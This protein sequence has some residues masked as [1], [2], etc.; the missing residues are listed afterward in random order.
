MVPGTAVANLS[1][2]TEHQ[3][4]GNHFKEKRAKAR[5]SEADRPAQTVTQDHEASSEGINSAEGVRAEGGE[6]LL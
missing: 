6:V 3:K 4:G 5:R 1:G 2:L